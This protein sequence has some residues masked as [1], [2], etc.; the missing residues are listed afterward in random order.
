VEYGRYGGAGG[1]HDSDTMILARSIAAPPLLQTRLP[2]R[3]YSSVDILVDTVELLL[4]GA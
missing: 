1:A 2:S 3:A 4:C